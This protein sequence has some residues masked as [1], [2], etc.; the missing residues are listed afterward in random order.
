MP[1]A[2]ALIVVVAVL[3]SLPLLA[4]D[5]QEPSDEQQYKLQVGL[6]NRVGNYS[7]RVL[8]GSEFGVVPVGLIEGEANPDEL[9]CVMRSASGSLTQLPSGRY[10]AEAA[11][12][13]AV[14]FAAPSESCPS[15]PLTDLGPDRW[16][17]VGVEA[18]DARGVWAAPSD[19]AVL[20][21]RCSPGPAAVFP[22]ALGRPFVDEV[23]VVG[24]AFAELT[25]TLAERGRER[26][27]V[28]WS[29]DEAV[30]TVPA[31]YAELTTYVDD[32]GEERARRFLRGTIPTGHSFP[33]SITILEHEF[34]LP[35]VIAVPVEHITTLEI[36]PLY[37]EVKEADAAQREWG[38]PI[39]A[40]AIARD[41]D[42][43]RVASVPVEWS[44]ARG[45]MALEPGTDLTIAADCK[46]APKRAEWRSATLE[47]SL[48]GLSAVAQFDWVAL[49]S[50]E[51]DP[52]APHCTGSAC[53]CSTAG[54]PSE[55]ALALLALLGLG[56][57]LRRRKSQSSSPE[58]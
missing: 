5:P 8:V 54:T 34:E 50:D 13:G 9:Q 12:P 47:A 49:P 56:F 19:A 36:V 18:S 55:S 2:S 37:M 20:E 46:R 6:D 45:R 27:E 31:H 32:D 10:L 53:D 15:G 33:A 57:G 29:D 23:R 24:G 28:R 39:G 3:G 41:G 40:L 25:P 22:N 44:V 11:G 4:C 52:S 30:L 1:R 43:R 35:P 17:L 21:Y 26:A 48:E 38:P 16:S 58:R 14:E 42:G 7:R 51:T